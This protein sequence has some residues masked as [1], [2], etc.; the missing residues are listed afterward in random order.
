MSA[1]IPDEAPVTSAVES[2]DGGGSG[3]A[4]ELIPRYAGGVALRTMLVLALAA[5]IAAGCGG[6]DDDDGGEAGTTP[7]ATQV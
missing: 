3:K 4:C 5:L 7:S 1:P 6:D 2:A